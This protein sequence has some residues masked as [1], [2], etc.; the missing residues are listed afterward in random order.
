MTNTS[1][2]SVLTSKV[3]VLARLSGRCA[4]GAHRDGGR[5]IHVVML[6]EGVTDPAWYRAL[7]GAEAGRRSGCGFVEVTEAEA[8][9]CPRCMASM[10]RQLARHRAADPHCTCNDCQAFA[11][12]E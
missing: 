6:P 8:A 7:C 1:K 5:R 10:Q 11:S 12:G 2:V 4:D 9:T 3:P